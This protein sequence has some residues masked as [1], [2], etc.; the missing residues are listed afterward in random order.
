V[1]DRLAGYAQG[2][3]D[4]RDALAAVELEEGQQ[5]AVVAGSGRAG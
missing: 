4:F 1:V 2:V 3:G 5:A